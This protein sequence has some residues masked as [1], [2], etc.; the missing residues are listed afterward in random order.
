MNVAVWCV[1]CW[2]CLF[3]SYCYA[4]ILN[5]PL[6]I[7]KVIWNWN[8]LTLFQLEIIFELSYNILT[9]NDMKSCS[10]HFFFSLTLM[11]RHIYE[12]WMRSRMTVWLQDK[13]H[14]P[15]NPKV[16]FATSHTV[17]TWTRECNI[18]S[19]VTEHIESNF[20]TKTQKSTKFPELCLCGGSLWSLNT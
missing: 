3:L 2:L 18:Q 4:P 12:T 17:S 7:N 16:P 8:I 14:C 20:P 15:F 9:L 19:P 10:S 13:I 6:G 11:R 5:C 1:C